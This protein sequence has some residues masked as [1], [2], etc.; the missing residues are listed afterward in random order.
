MT[1]LS[2]TPE[3]RAEAFVADMTLAYNHFS[4]CIQKFFFEGERTSCF[5]PMML[6]QN[7]QQVGARKAVSTSVLLPSSLD[8]CGTINS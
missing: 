4:E 3:S 7:D 8:S 2:S 1:T 6:C 5:F